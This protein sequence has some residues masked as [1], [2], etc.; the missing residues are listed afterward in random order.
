[1]LQALR[2]EADDVLVVERVE[3]LFSG[4]ARP[5]ES[6][7]AQKAQLVRDSGLGE[8]ETPRDVLHAELG[9]GQRVKNADP[10]DVPEHPE[11]LCQCGHGLGVE[12]LR[13]GS[14]LPP[15]TQQMNI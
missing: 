9:A 2:K 14:S 12:E 8:I 10:G 11:S 7:A 3:D 1:M 13:L 6:H 15:I 4:A 5:Y